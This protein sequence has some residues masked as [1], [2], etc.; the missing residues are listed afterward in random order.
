MYKLILVLLLSTLFSLNS[1]FIKAEIIQPDQQIPANDSVPAAE[2]AV[3]AASAEA[4]AIEA[5][6]Q[7]AAAEAASAEAEAIEAAQQQAAAEAAVEAASAEAEAIEAAQQAAVE[8][9][10][11]EYPQTQQPMY[12][13][14][15][16]LIIYISIAILLFISLLINY[17]L[18]RWRAKYKN[19]LVTFP[20]NL[21]DKFV[22]LNKGFSKISSGVKNEF[23]TFSNNLKS[24]TNSHQ[25]LLGHISQRYDEIFESF[26]LLQGSLNEKDKEIDR[27]KRGYDLQIIKK[28]VKKLIRVS[29]ICQTINMDENISEETKKEVIFVYENLQDIIDEI[30]VKQFSIN[31][32]AS[33]KSDEFGIPPANEWVSIETSNEDKIFLVK[34]TLVEGFYIEAEQKEVLQYPKIEV[35]VKGDKNE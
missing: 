31:E 34:Q 8:A 6:Q 3:E 15:S 27:L 26:G 29:N 12:S 25:Q 1:I 35:Y 17:I 13:Q 16:M 28:F 5:A 11:K 2:A 32:G 18:L 20:E 14:S 19:Q 21:L 22:D 33:V 24:Q 23:D 10:F 4:E 30:G 9:N 7:Q